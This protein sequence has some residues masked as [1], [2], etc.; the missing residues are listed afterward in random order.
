MLSAHYRLTKHHF[1]QYKTNNPAAAA[2]QDIATTTMLPQAAKAVASLSSMPKKLS[3]TANLS[4][5]TV[6]ARSVAMPTLLPMVRAAAVPVGQF[7]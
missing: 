6:S 1:Q 3:A 5:Q 7:F 4:S 2:V